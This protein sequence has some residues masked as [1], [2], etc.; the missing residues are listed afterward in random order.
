MVNEI[1][2]DVQTA[3]QQVDLAKSQLKSAVSNVYPQLGING[4]Y[5][6]ELAI[7]N[8]TLAPNTPLNPTP[9]P[10]TE[11]AYNEQIF[12][13][14][15]NLQQVVFDNR[16]FSG[17][18]YEK[19]GLVNAKANFEQVR[20][21]A[22]LQASR[23][24]FQ[25]LLDKRLVDVYQANVSYSE[26]NYKDIKE[27][28]E[29]GTASQYDLLRAEVQLAN[30]KPALIEA[31]NNLVLAQN[32]LR[33]LLAKD[34]QAKIGF[35]GSIYDDEPNRVDVS[36][37]RNLML[38]S[39]TYQE[40]LWNAKQAE[41]NVK[42]SLGDLWPSLNIDGAYIHK[43][44]KLDQESGN[45]A[46]GARYNFYIGLRLSYSLFS[47]F[48]RR[49]SIRQSKLALDIANIRVL[50]QEQNLNEQITQ[51]QLNV[52]QAVDQIEAQRTSLTAA[53]KAVEISFT[54]YREGAGTLLEILDTQ[55][56]YVT[57]ESNY[58]KA[59]YQ[60]LLSEARLQF[61]TTGFSDAYLSE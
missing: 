2:W 16:V 27:G 3:R 28:Y 20:A 54:R 59:Y 42:V 23:L 34:P 5:T 26:E 45:V 41:Q 19:I 49:E 56:A 30:S 9:D 22:K 4:N 55:A 50:Q 51:A 10:V 43:F 32:S 24:F 57:A 60:Y 47:G 58:A 52:N 25:I 29:N 33:V 1:N 12:T 7:P 18:K 17:I 39:V 48:G 44:D 31:K 8:V 40:A 53:N 13:G 36:L 21:Q 35:T 46:A 6:R 37:A 14:M 15:A 61:L 11:K 38:S